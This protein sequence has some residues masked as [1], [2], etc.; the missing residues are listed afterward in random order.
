MQ[1]NSKEIDLGMNYP[2]ERYPNIHWYVLGL[3]LMDGKYS[4][5]TQYHTPVLVQIQVFAVRGI[6]CS[7]FV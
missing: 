1:S 2:D 3:G 6:I 5:S 7:H 4:V